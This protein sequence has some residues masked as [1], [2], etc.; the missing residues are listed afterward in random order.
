MPKC[1]YSAKKQGF[2][3]IESLKVDNIH[4]SPDTKTGWAK[5]YFA[6]ATKGEGGGNWRNVELLNDF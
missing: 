4:R 3:E 5:P 6:K 2:Q 1:L